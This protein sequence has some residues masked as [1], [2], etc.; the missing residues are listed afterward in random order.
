MQ[1]GY[2]Q[3]TISIQSVYNLY[4]QYTINIQ[5]VYNQYTI[6]RQSVDNHYTINIQSVYNQQTISRQSIYNHY[7]I[8][9]QSIYNQY[10]I[11]RQ[12]VYNQYAINILY[13][14]SEISFHFNKNI[15]TWRRDCVMQIMLVIPLNTFTNVSVNIIPDQNIM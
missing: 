9:I 6:S 15:H 4:N 5:S 11:S 14:C 3:H 13:F 10:I 1:S 7:T 12:S 8:I 2:N